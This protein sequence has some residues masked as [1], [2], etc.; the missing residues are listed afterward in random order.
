MRVCL[1]WSHLCR[2]W[3]CDERCEIGTI[4]SGSYVLSSPHAR[5]DFLCAGRDYGVGCHYFQLEQS[6]ALVFHRL[7]DRVDSGGMNRLETGWP[8]AHGPV[9]RSVPSLR[10]ARSLG[11]A[12]GG[13]PKSKDGAG[14]ARIQGTR[15]TPLRR[16]E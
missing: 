4:H 1:A 12:S 14:F 10:Y 7:V 6:A 3:R 13:S 16:F 9:K 11:G 2:I 15:P 5:A 8:T